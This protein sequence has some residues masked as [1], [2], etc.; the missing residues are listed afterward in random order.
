PTPRA[1]APTP[2]LEPVVIESVDYPR[3]ALAVGEVTFTG[4]VPDSR[5]IAAFDAAGVRQP[6]DVVLVS[7]PDS[8]VGVFELVPRDFLT[9]GQHTVV[10]VA[11]IPL[12]PPVTAEVDAWAAGA[13]DAVQ[14]GD[15][16]RLDPADAERVTPWPIAASMDAVPP[17][18]FAVEAVRPDGLDVRVF[19]DRSTRTC[20]AGQL[21]FFRGPDGVLVAEEARRTV[22]F[23]GAPMD[24][25][26]GRIQLA[27]DGD[28]PGMVRAGFTIDLAQ[29]RGPDRPCDIVDPFGEPA[30]CE[31]CP[32][33]AEAT[34]LR[35]DVRGIPATGDFPVLWGDR[36]TC[37]FE[38]DPDDALG[39]CGSGPLACAGGGNGTW[40]ALAPGVLARRP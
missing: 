13:L 5:E 16:W 35:F 27:L 21:T 39:S 32:G 30:A 1:V 37:V 28:L 7:H 25:L 34:C 23:G 2:P 18:T 15:T 31:P 14:V 26:D 12:D 11:G 36:P 20:D 10:S 4:P 33:G 6:F 38:L 22:A 29:I 3:Q 24:L 9:P 17:V 40:G 8:A 19:V